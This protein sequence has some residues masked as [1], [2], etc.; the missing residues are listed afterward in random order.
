MVGTIRMD[1]RVNHPPVAMAAVSK[2]VA[3]A[4]VSK[5]VAMAVVSK[6][7][8]MAVVSKVAA[9]AV[10]SKAVAMAVV[11]KVVA[12][13]VVT[14]AAATAVVNRHRVMGRRV[15]VMVQ[16]TIAK[17]RKLRHRLRLSKRLCLR[18]NLP[19]KPSSPQMRQGL[20]SLV[21]MGMIQFPS[22]GLYEGQFRY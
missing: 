11:S 22:K 16:L 7:V 2:A 18:L 13:V 10:V 14:K 9:M 12:M 3:M 1:I 8:A 19:L 5:A 6:A 20:V 4:A 15:V 21:K 17:H